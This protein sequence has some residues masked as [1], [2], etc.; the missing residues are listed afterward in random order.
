[1]EFVEPVGD[2]LVVAVDRQRVLREVVRAEGGEVDPGGREI[3]DLKRARGCLD[4]H[5]PPVCLGINPGLAHVPFDSL[6][7]VCVVDEGNITS[8][9]SYPIS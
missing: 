7:V 1:V 6:D 8:K 3:L 4:H 9:L 2:V 5:A